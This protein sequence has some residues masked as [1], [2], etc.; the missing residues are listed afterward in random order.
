LQCWQVFLLP[1]AVQIL[2]VN[3]A[4]DGLPAIALGLSPCELDVMQ[5]RQETQIKTIFTKD[6]RVFH[7]GN[8]NRN[9]TSTMDIH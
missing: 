8:S 3:L 4:T 1:L 7:Q 5:D 2:Y 9:P 6:V